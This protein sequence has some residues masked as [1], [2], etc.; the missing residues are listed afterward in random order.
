MDAA[1][2]QHLLNCSSASGSS[3]NGLQYLLIGGPVGERRHLFYNHIHNASNML[4]HVASSSHVVSRPPVEDLVSN[5]KLKVF[6]QLS[7]HQ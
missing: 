1:G 3:T 2:G 4:T 6:F 5:V 7:L